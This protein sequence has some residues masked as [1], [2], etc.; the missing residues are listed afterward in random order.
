[1]RS[2]LTLI[3]F[4]LSFTL[5]VGVAPASAQ[6][7]VDTAIDAVLVIDNSG[8]MTENDPGDM[9]ISAAKLFSNLAAKGDQIGV[10]SM[11]DRDSTQAILSLSRVDITSQLSWDISETIRKPAELSNWTYMGGALDLSTQV[12]ENTAQPNRQRAVLLLTDG[13]PTYRDED[14]ADQEAKFNAAVERL[15][16]QGVKIFPIALGPDAD[17][18]F[19]QE[20]LATPTNGRVWRAESADQLIGVYT[21]IMALLQDGRYLDAYEVVANV[22]AFLADVNPRQQIRQINFVFPARNGKAPVINSLLLPQTATSGL[23]KMSRFEDPNWSMFTARPEYVPRFNGE[24]RVVLND[25]ASQ[26]PV[27]AVIKSDLRARL[28]EPTPN[29]P[30]DDAAVRY[31]PAGRPLLLRAGARNNADRFEKRLGVQAQM[32]A[33]TPGAQ[34]PLAD[35]GAGADLA[36][37]DGMYG[38]LIAE[39]LQPGAYRIAVNLSA[40]DKHVRLAKPYDLIVEPLPTMQIAFEPNGKLDVN[41]PV[42]LRARFALDDQPVTVEDAEIT[43]AVK[44]DDKVV[45]TVALEPD[46]NGEWIGYYVPDQAGSL[47]V[48]LTAHVTW[49]RPDGQTRRYTDYVEANYAAAQQALVEVAVVDNG[50][51]VNDLRDGIQ[52]TLM[53]QSYSDEPVDLTLDVTGVPEGTVYPETLRIEPRGSGQRTITISSPA[54]LRSGEWQAQLVVEGPADVQ[55]SAAQHD[56]S[57]A[58]NGFLARYRFLL[59]LAVGLLLLLIQRR[60]RHGVRDLLSRN[61]ELLRYGGR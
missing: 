49:N 52:R 20:Q 15:K 19:L 44:R 29:A 61:V 57:F 25:D 3:L 6:N 42:T 60:V 54:E 16:A 45:T 43:A 21:E 28:I 17:V 1:M 27:T 11:G 8:S 10:V 32:L 48:G 7:T 23:D 9:R 34:L 35:S 41:Q 13:L 24:W 14:R 56:L 53:F 39:P 31:Y 47:S 12:L 58:V 33:P 18:A 22:E 4:V 46:G 2:S 51:R 37:E 59:L 40:T 50:G 38:G 36:P 55:L 26:I 30:D 5:L